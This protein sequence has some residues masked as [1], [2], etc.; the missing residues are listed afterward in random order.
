MQLLTVRQV[1]D[2]LSVSTK[3]IYKMFS[4][5]K[6]DGYKIE[7]AVRIDE[8]SLD[9]YLQANR[10]EKKKPVPTVPTQARAKQA[11]GRFKYL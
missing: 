8:A 11:R 7:G 5:G 2:R 6:L 9:A 1:A 3:L 10:I 4:A